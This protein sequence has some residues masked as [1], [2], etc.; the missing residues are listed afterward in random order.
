MILSMNG[1]RQPGGAPGTVLQNA[2]LAAVFAGSIHQ[3]RRN[4]FGRT[5][6]R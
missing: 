2:S 1:E 5:L 3:A 6:Q 4:L